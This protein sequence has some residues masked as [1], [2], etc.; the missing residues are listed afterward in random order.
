MLLPNLI[1]SAHTCVAVDRDRQLI[2]GG[3]AAAPMLRLQP[4]PGPG[5]VL[6]V[7][8]PC[9]RRGVGSTLLQHLEKA[10]QTSPAKVL[11]AA[12][13]VDTASYEMAAWQRLGFQPCERVEE[14][15]LPVDGIAARLVPIVE[16]MRT[17]GRIPANA[18]VVPLYKADR[19][20]VLQLHL[21][22]MGGNRT[23]LTQKLRGQVS[24]AF[25]PR[26]S[27][28]LLIDGK[29]QGCLLAS[30]TCKETIVVD[31]NIVHPSLR[32][33]WANAWLKLEAFRGTPPGV[34]Q[35]KFTSFD[36]YTDTRS[37]TKK[38]G[39]RTVRSTALLY[40]PISKSLADQ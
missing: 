2:I 36:H 18:R 38:F 22:Q 19:S 24:G 15:L 11:Y 5:V 6:H 31:A 33:D 40:R 17:H 13:R 28:V 1:D 27:R 9:R 20:A 8:P 14:H 26:Q 23:E 34:V 29:V 21:D 16:R 4:F 32:G 30:R 35:F 37:F 25:L 12:S 3:A 7:I 10:A 39:G